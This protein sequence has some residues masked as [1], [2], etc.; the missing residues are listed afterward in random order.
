MIL[1]TAHEAEFWHTAAVLRVR[2]VLR[3]GIRV[4]GGRVGLKVKEIA[5]H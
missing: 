4:R 3:A 2:T 1:R 5:Y